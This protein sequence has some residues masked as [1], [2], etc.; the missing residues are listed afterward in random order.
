MKS[1]IKGKYVAIYESF[2]LFYLIFKKYWLFK[3]KTKII[4]YCR[5]I[6]YVEVKSMMC[7]KTGKG[8]WKHAFVR[9][10]HYMWSGIILFE[11]RLG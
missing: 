3:Y 10:L 11:G 4:K 1:A 9:L 6:I 2:F 5:P 8:E 7:T